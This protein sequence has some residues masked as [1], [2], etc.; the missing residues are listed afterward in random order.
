MP[1]HKRVFTHLGDVY[2]LRPPGFRCIPTRDLGIVKLAELA[3]EIF[4]EV[5]QDDGFNPVRARGLH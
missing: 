1:G 5:L 2:D 4:L 3:Q